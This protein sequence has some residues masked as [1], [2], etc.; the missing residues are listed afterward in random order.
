MKVRMDSRGMPIKR[1]VIGDKE[2]Y[3]S[4]VDRVEKHKKRVKNYGSNAQ[5]AATNN[6]QESHPKQIESNSDI[7]LTF[8]TMTQHGESQQNPIF[9]DFNS[10]L[11]P[12]DSM[13]R[14]LDGTIMNRTF[15]TTSRFTDNTE[16][17]QKALER[18]SLKKNDWNK[19]V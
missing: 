8:H 7:N 13:H 6:L 9:V 19:F 4:V 18:H 15:G 1:A 12:M 2:T 10:T 16:R 14:T 3:K 11:Q 17:L 5:F